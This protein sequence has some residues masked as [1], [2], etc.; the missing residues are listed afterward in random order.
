[1]KKLLFVFTMLLL[2]GTINAYAKDYTVSVTV[3]ET[4]VYKKG[5]VEQF[6]LGNGASLQ[7]IVVAANSE[8][9]ARRKAITE[10]D[11]MCK[12]DKSLSN[13]VREGVTY[14]VYLHKE[15]GD[16]SIR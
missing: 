12:I 13:E 4:K 8:D 15:V 7:N 2:L 16:A 1:M 3:Y 6:R 9:D 11:K 5:G 10:C 14:Q